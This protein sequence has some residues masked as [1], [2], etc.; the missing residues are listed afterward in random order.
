[1]LGL[2]ALRS[3]VGRV[4]RTLPA[5]VTAAIEAAH[6]M[7][8]SSDPEGAPRLAVALGGGLL[9]GA[10]IWSTEEA[11]RRIVRR[12]PELNEGQVTRAV[13]HLGSRVQ[14][15]AAEQNRDP[16]RRRER[17]TWLNRW[18]YQD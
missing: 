15:V 9:R 14:I 17:K 3:L 18:R 11:T 6:V 13:R 2:S 4:N 16:N 7:P 8:R 5:D 1:M 12:W 10:F